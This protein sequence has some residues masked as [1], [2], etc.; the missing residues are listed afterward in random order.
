MTKMDADQDA[1]THAIIGAAIEVHNQL[2]HGFLEPVYQEAMAIELAARNI[3]FDKEVDLIVS[4]KGTPLRCGYR[5]DFICFHE[6][7]VEIKALARVGGVEHAQ[8]LNYLKATG[9]RLGLL[10]NFGGSRL[11]V[12]RLRFDP[13]LCSLS[14]S[15]T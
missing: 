14:P 13:E 9:L 15:A 3:A 11:E 6:I 5:A 7:I 2:G 10:L 1:R 8:V 12:K 4:Y